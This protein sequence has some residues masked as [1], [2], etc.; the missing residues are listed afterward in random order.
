M[1]LRLRLIAIVLALVPVSFAQATRCSLLPSDTKAVVEQQFPDWRPK[2]LSDLSGYDKK[3]W[4]EIHPKECPGIA[5]GHFEQPG[6]IAYAVFLIP[7]SGHT[8]SYKIIVLSKATN[9]YA[10]RLLDHGEGSTYSDSGLV[11]SKEQHG[12]YSEFGD[13]KTVRLKLDGVNVEWL[14]KSSVLYYWSHGKYRSIQT[15]D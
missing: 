1:R 7:K 10:V 11:I 15:G 12:T 14:E 2:V 5:V 8:A 9:E 3:L 13:T 4:L 6:R